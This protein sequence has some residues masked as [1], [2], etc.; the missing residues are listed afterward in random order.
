MKKH[1]ALIDYSSF[2]DNKDHN[3]VLNELVDTLQS[4]QLKIYGLITDKNK[5]KRTKVNKNV[6]GIMNF[7]EKDLKYDSYKFIS[8][9]ML[10]TRCSNPKNY[11]VISANNN[12]IRTFE[13][14]GFETNIIYLTEEENMIMLSN[15]EMKELK[16]STKKIR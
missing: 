12:V 2:A 10:L 15:K 16:K 13:N 7:N 8:R 3:L 9:V 5:R 1:I 11:I 4:R 6:S 14:N